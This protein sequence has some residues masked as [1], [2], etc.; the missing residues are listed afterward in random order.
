[1]AD[2]TIF[3]KNSGGRF[4]IDRYVRKGKNKKKRRG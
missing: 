4:F 1:M 3:L 2:K